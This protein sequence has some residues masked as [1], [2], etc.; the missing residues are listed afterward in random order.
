MQQRVAAQFQS[1]VA[2]TAKRGWRVCIFN[3][4]QQRLTFIINRSIEG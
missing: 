4:H 3:E 2:E 1:L